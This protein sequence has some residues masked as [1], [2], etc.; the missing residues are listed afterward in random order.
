MD[1]LLEKL[2]AEHRSEHTR[3][4]QEE[5]DFSAIEGA[6]LRVCLDW[7]YTRQIPEFIEAVAQERSAPANGRR[8][9]DADVF[10]YCLFS[11]WPGMPFS[12]LTK[13]ERRSI[14]IELE[15]DE[16]FPAYKAAALDWEM[17]DWRE[18]L[19]AQIQELL[20]YAEKYGAQSAMK[21]AK[22]YWGDFVGTSG[23]WFQTVM[24]NIDLQKSPDFL[25]KAF[26]ELIRMKRMGCKIEIEETRGAGNAFRQLRTKLKWLGALRL[27]EVMSWESAYVHTHELMGKGLFG[28]R[29]E[30]WHTAKKRATNELSTRKS[31]TQF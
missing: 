17:D 22:E 13:A 28:N 7:E 5:W 26:R 19:V 6:E 9:V 23:H 4:P 24:L 14:I 16:G 31:Q 1:Y 11:E 18:T 15:N 20:N 21:V 10:Q 27:L 2:A 3:I 25:T 29:P 30:L 12:R 8:F